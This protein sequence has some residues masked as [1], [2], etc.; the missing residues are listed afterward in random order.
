MTR[1]PTLGAGRVNF[2]E[3]FYKVYETLQMPN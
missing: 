2:Q 1:P 3:S